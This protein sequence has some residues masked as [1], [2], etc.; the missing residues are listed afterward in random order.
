MTQQ[1]K[2]LSSL[3][4]LYISQFLSAFADNLNFFIIIGIIMR[5]GLPNPD[6]YVTYIQIGILFAYVVLA[7]VVGAFADRNPKSVVLF[8]GNFIKAFG[9]VVLIMG[10]HPIIAYTIVGIGAVIYSPAKYGILPEL[11]HTEDQLLR[12]N[13]MVEGSTILAIALGT[14]T[15]GFLAAISDLTGMLTSAT[16]YI[17]SLLIALLIPRMY[18]NRTIRYGASA[19]GFFRDI[20][21]LLANAKARF[22]LIGTGAFW[23]STA[24]LRIALIAFMLEVLLISDMSK[25]SMLLG[26]VAIGVIFSAFFTARLVPAGKLYRAFYYGFLMGGI[27]LF[28][29][30]QSS[31]VLTVFVL[32]GLGFFGGVFLIPLNTMLQETGKSLIGSGKTIAIQNF[33]EN[34]ISISGLALYLTLSKSSLSI[35]WTMAI[36]GILLLL[37]VAYLRTQLGLIKDKDIVSGQEIDGLK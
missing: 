25:Q 9:I 32:L 29:A 16:F 7:P 23:L 13:A 19:K 11:T 15:G 35:Q 12:A 14:V 31:V 21:V 33:V 37:I 27:V 28:G 3:N 36:F 17:L 5:Q 8:I 2:R 34:T 6:L 30:F 22:S 26:V 10:V 1:R 24:V 18:G 20:K 4:A